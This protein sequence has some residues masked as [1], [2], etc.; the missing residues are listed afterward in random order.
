ME[1]FWKKFFNWIILLEKF[2]T[3]CY[4][5]FDNSRGL[6]RASPPMAVGLRVD[7]LASVLQEGCL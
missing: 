5:I 1:I 7:T 6:P 3:L 4:T 2:K